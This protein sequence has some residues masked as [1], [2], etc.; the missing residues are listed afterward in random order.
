MTV[1][2]LKKQARQDFARGVAAEREKLTP[3]Q[4]LHEVTMQALTH[5]PRGAYLSA[6]VGQEARTKEWYVKE[7]SVPQNDGEGWGLWAARVGEI[8]KAVIAQLPA[9]A[10]GGES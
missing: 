9:T 10:N 6:T 8:A 2:E 3:T 4:R 5:T 1:A 7:L